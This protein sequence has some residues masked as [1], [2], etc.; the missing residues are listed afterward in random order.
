MILAEH[1]MWNHKILVNELMMEI[2][3]RIEKFLLSIS[4]FVHWNQFNNQ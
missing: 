3:N 4:L 1:F 2:L